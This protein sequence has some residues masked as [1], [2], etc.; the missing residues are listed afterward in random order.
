[1]SAWSAARVSKPIQPLIQVIDSYSNDI[2]QIILNIKTQ[3]QSEVAVEIVREKVVRYLSNLKSQVSPKLN[4]MLE[5]L[6]QE[7]TKIKVLQGGVAKS[8][9]DNELDKVK[10]LA[11]SAILAASSA[12]EAYITTTLG[13]TITKLINKTNAVTK[14]ETARVTIMKYFGG[15]RS[16]SDKLASLISQ[17][18]GSISNTS[19][20]GNKCTFTYNNSLLKPITSSITIPYTVVCV[21]KYFP[22]IVT[23]DSSGNCIRRI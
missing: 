1:L 9:V 12:L 6:R 22:M 11:E 23:A 21:A 20:S 16:L 19:V 15:V 14:L 2:N 10:V 3:M 13:S 4:Q 17:G 8:I 18:L 7:I 5:K